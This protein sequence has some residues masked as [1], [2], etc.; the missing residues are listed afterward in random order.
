MADTKTIALYDAKAG[1]YADLIASD[2]PDAQLQA[3]MAMLPPGG[4]VLDLGCGPGTASVHLRNA[5]FQPLAV[6]AS[7]GMIALAQKK[8]GLNAQQMRFDEIDMVAA[9]DGIW[10]NF[11]L[12]HAPRSALPDHLAALYTALRPGGAFHIGM[13]TGEG[14]DRDQIERLYTY[15]TIPELTQLLQDAGLVPCGQDEGRDMGFAGTLDPWVVIRA[16]KPL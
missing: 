12:L 10:A 5:G 11:S 15:V 9:F 1:D 7:A 6:D 8:Y 4:S 13:K 14:E 16:R 3:F 2:T